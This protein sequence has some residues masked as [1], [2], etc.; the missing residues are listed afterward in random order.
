MRSIRKFAYA[1]ALG[2]SLLAIQPTL[3]TAEEARGSFTLTHEV[4]CQNV[5]LRP[6]EYTFTVD[7]KGSFE[8][9]TLRGSNGGTSAMLMVDTVETSKPDQA[10]RLVL[11]S[12]EGQSFV[13]AMELPHYDM[14][15]R[16]AVP[17]TGAL[18]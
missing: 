17:S 1:A 2:L 15:L 14:S 12:R 10:S 8:F 16:F 3:A 4:R 13:S 5:I 11:V 6:G 9:V 7:T 18:K